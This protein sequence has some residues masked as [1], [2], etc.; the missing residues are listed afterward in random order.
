MGIGLDPVEPAAGGEE[1]GAVEL[2]DDGGGL[3]ESWGYQEQELK[4]ELESG[5]TADDAWRMHG[6]DYGS[7]GW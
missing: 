5:A 3:G 1:K 7:A 4:K 2:F 6:R